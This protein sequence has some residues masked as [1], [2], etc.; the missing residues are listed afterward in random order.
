MKLPGLLFGV[1]VAGACSR[2][3]PERL[4]VGPAADSSPIGAKCLACHESIVR[5]YR[6]TGMAQALERIHPGELD[7]LAPVTDA[8]GWTYRFGSAEGKPR[9]V[10]TWKDGSVAIDAELAFAIGAGLMD[11]SYAAVVGDLLWFAPIE[12]I[13]DP[14]DRH[15][16]LAPGHEMRAG[17]R[18]TTPIFEECLACHTDNLPPRGYPLNLRPDPA[19]WSPSGISCAAC[20]GDVDGHVEWR[21]RARDG[22]AHTQGNEK[23]PI[24]A[25]SRLGA[26]ESLSLCARCHLQ[27]D[28]SFL[29]EPGARGIVPPEGDMLDRRAVFLAAGRSEEIRFVSQVERLLFSPCYSGAEK[30]GHG[31]MTC[32]TCHDPHKSSFDPA[33]RR[34]VRDACQQCHASEQESC[35]KPMAERGGNDCVDCHMRRT[36]VFDVAH[37]EIHDHFIRRNPGAPSPRKPLRV[38]ESKDGSFAVFAWPGREPPPYTQDPGLWM[39]VEIASGHSDLALPFAE[40]EPGPASARLPTYHH[41]RGL[42][43]ESLDRNEDARAAYA[44]G[45]EL[46]P[47]S[48]ECAVNL[49]L[50][51]GKLGRQREG[52]AVLDQAIEAHPAAWTALRNRGVMRFQLGDAEGCA[53]DLERAF[54]IAPDA[55]VAGALAGHYES[56]GR[57]E[58]A[59]RW[60]RAAIQLDPSRAALWR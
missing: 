9:L 27:G 38:H 43:F 16:A 59:A 45:L 15:A 37:V 55:T 23:D 39:M 57:P 3:T 51:L 11:R 4:E 36:G 22:I 2:E 41:L 35:T 32:V 10:E 17:T 7:D 1:L 31:P 44:R 20:H 28:A 30:S 53:A 56:A 5:S 12:L 42:L 50:V 60:K 14:K 25:A 58:E 18:F 29:L 54:A 6:E 34:V 19:S 48:A 21:E 52:I 33:E 47:T 26:I 40:R 49:G 24:L 13:T 8:A 46:D